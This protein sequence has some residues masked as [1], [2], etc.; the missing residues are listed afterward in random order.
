MHIFDKQTK[1]DGE[2]KNDYDVT[3]DYLERLITYLKL[4]GD[5]TL[6]QI[7]SNHRKA[8][9]GEAYLSDFEKEILSFLKQF[10]SM[11]HRMNGHGYQDYLNLKDNNQ[12]IDDFHAFD[13]NI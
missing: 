2:M 1:E 5:K 10:L 6:K 8:I 9:K 3:D 11:K 12:I 4:M 13:L 7:Y